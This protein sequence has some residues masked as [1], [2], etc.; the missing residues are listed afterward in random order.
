MK[1]GVELRLLDQI[2]LVNHL[3]RNFACGYSDD[4]RFF[5]LTE[6]GVY[7]LGLKCN[8]SATFTNFSCSKKFFE[9]SNFI[10]SGNVDLDINTFHKDL[11]RKALYESV[12][13]TEYSASLKH[14]KAVDFFPVCAEW[15]P[16][17][18]VGNTNCMLGVLT[19][20]HSLEIYS[21]FL[22]E[23]EQINYSLITNVT[24]NIISIQRNK[25]KDATRFS[26]HGKMEEFKNRVNSV[27]VS[28]ICIFISRY[29]VCISL[30]P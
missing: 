4:D 17:G 24:E 30:H 3:T 23:N 6:S 12:M 8:L 9:V 21:N 25:W 1:M 13:A 14:T 5:I 19:N 11:D 29:L 18:I 7:V 15:S 2:K 16:A 26:I 28:V 10:P 27:A 22:D 20:T